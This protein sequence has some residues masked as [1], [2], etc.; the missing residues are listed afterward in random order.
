MKKIL[1][2]ALMASI[3][4]GC[5]SDGSREIQI[6]EVKFLPESKYDKIEDCQKVSSIFEIVPGK[7]DLSWRLVHDMPLSQN[8]NVELKLKLRLK[9]SVKVL[10]EVF[11]KMSNTSY[12]ITNNNNV[13]CPFG[14]YLV[15]ANGE[16]EKSIVQTL[17]IDY[18]PLEDWQGKGTYN[19]DQM[20]DFVN[21]LAS[22]P[23]AEIEVVCNCLGMKSGPND[24]KEIIKNARGIQCVMDDT[25]REFER[26]FGTI[27]E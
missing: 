1:F 21:F 6:D 4:V 3:F 22:K 20:M 16:P 12:E 24:C 14:F 13:R 8:Y 17:R 9:K 10:P 18:L 25:D 27:V 7:Y 23:G 15:N 19:K 11:E 26:N 2:M 5:S